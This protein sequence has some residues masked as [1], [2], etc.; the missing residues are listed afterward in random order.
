MC[1]SFSV[2]F[3][4]KLH[5]CQTHLTGPFFSHMKTQNHLEHAD[6]QHGTEPNWAGKHKTS[7]AFR[8]L[9]CVRA[10]ISETKAFET[11]EGQFIQAHWGDTGNSLYTL[12]SFQCHQHRTSAIGPLRLRNV[13]RQNTVVITRSIH[14]SFSQRQDIQKKREPN[15]SIVILFRCECFPVVAPPWESNTRNFFFLLIVPQNENCN[16]DSRTFSRQKEKKLIRRVMELNSMCRQARLTA[17]HKSQDGKCIA[18][19]FPHH[20][21]SCGLT[22]TKNWT[23]PAK[24]VFF[25]Q[26]ACKE[27]SLCSH[28]RA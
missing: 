16:F 26:F 19:A 21:V 1:F 5:S 27:L 24:K 7:G 8:F 9:N 17:Q 28:K 10:M 20:S 11:T 3:L 15:L 12:W 25:F 4:H 22:A 23:F 18:R 14:S 2:Y 13:S 6:T